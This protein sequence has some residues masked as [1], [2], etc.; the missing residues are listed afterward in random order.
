MNT[1]HPVTVLVGIN[2]FFSFLI[3]VNPPFLGTTWTGLTQ[4]LSEIESPVFSSFMFLVAYMLLTIF[5]Q[6]LDCF[7]VLQTRRQQ[8]RNDYQGQRMTQPFED[9]M[10]QFM[11]YN[12]RPVHLH[13][14]KLSDLEV[15]KLGTQ[16][17]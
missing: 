10:L 4:E 3:T 13:E 2:S 6:A 16:I 14:Q 11:G 7:F 12:N 9:Q 8:F 5:I 1:L 15:F 17:V